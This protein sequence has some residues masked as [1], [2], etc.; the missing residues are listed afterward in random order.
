MPDLATTLEPQPLRV[1]AIL[2]AYN[3]S[4]QARRAVQALEK[5]QDR[6]RL[7]IIVVDCGSTDGTRSLD[8]EF[9]S[10][11]MLRL[12]HH[13]GAARAWNI[14]TRTAKAPLLFFVS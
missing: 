13:I 11:N 10:V 1:S 7:E 6:E 5:S 12:P 8:A 9:P 3:Q 4:A 14:A 2:L